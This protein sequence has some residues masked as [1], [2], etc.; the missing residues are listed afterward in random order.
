MH[1]LHAVATFTLISA[2]LLPILSSSSSA[3]DIETVTRASIETTRLRNDANGLSR[4]VSLNVP[5]LL[6]NPE[7]PTGCESVALTNALLFYGFDLTKTEIADAWLPT[8][9]TDFVDAFMGSP[10]SPDGHATMAPAIV[11]TATSYL[12]AQ[13]SSLTAIDLTGNSLEDILTEV[14]QGYPVIA[15][16]TIELEEPNNPY[17]TVKEYDRTYHLFANTHTVVVRGYDLDANVIFVSD[18]LSGQVTYD[19]ET[20]AARYYALG[21]QAVVIK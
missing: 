9:D 12:E 5:A 10:F 15:W 1:I 6:Q 16:C 4:S 20:F 7:L 11:H 18:S 14:D 3:V 8:S 21:S 2:L 13:G 17:M 19:L